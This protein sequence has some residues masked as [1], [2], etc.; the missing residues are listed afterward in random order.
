MIADWEEEELILKSQTYT[1]GGSYD[2][3]SE[4]QLRGKKKKN[5]HYSSVGSNHV[6]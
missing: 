2:S 4:S 5:T 3:G 6:E 1:F